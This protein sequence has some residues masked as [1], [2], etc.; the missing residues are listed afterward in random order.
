MREDQERSKAGRRVVM[1]G[2]GAITSIGVGRQGL[3]E[4]VLRGKSAVQRIT[5]F[6][7]SPFRSQIA[8]QVNDFDPQSWLPHDSK[9]IRRMDRYSQFALT[10]ALMAVD[11]AGLDIK[12]GRS[13]YDPD[14]FGI[15]IGTALGGVSFA[16]EQHSVFLEGGPKAVNPSLALSIFGGAASCNIAIDLGVNGPNIANANSCASGAIAL[17][18]AYRLIK[19]GGAKAMLAGGVEVPLA[20]LTYYAFALIRAHSTANDTPEIACR[21]FDRN[22]DGFVMAEG[23]AI[24]LLEDYESAVERGAHI[25]G[26]I[27]GYGTSNDGYNMV[28]PLPS[29]KQASRSM[30]LALREAGIEPA[31]VGYINAHASSTPLNDKA[32][33]AAIKTVFGEGA[34][35]MPISGTK[36]MHAHALGA[37]G[38]IEAAIC[39]LTLDQGYLPPSVNLR[40]RD[41]DCDLNYITEG[42]HRKVDYI[43]SNSFGFGG[44]NASLVFGRVQD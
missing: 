34:Y 28:A 5:R 10:A 14:E 37:T 40:E 6:D 19:T 41:P 23:A 3:W 33:T 35:K 8:A 12:G 4:G 39:G 17:G 32:E 43:L 20:P 29:G 13:P 7:P 22:R 1:T 42:V 36:G 31:Q 11:D 30:N 27:A 16:E 26:E 18:E 25:Y 24:M 44:I 2:I 9:Q 15:F 21:P 38:A